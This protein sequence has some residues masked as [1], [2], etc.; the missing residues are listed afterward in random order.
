[1]S[2]FSAVSVIG[3]EREWHLWWKKLAC[4]QI[5]RLEKRSC[6]IC[7]CMSYLLIH[8]NPPLRQPGSSNSALSASSKD[9]RTGLPCLVYST[10]AD[11]EREPREVGCGMTASRSRKNGMMFGCLRHQALPPSLHKK[12]LPSVLW[13]RKVGQL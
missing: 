8:D 9:L 7:S 10:P 1:M 12:L 11:L 5:L 2:G 3:S 6:S 4:K 13:T